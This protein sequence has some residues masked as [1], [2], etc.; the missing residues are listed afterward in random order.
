MEEF[1]GTEHSGCFSSVGPLCSTTTVGYSIT[2]NVQN[3]E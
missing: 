1:G 3:W 2:Q